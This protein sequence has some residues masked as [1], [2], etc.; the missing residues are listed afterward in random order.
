L[1]KLSPLPLAVLLIVA[2][3]GG[4]GIAARVGS[5]VITVEEV[6]ALRV[7]PEEGT[8]DKAIFAADLSEA[9]INR[10]LADGVR[11]EFGIEPTA[12]ELAAKV[13]EFRDLVNEQQGMELEEFLLSRE[14]TP[15]RFDIITYQAVVRDRMI[16][17]FRPRIVPA[18]AAEAQDLI[19]EQGLAVINACVSHILVATESE[20]QLA[21]ARIDGGEDFA[22]VARELGTDGTAPGG[23]SLGCAPL[24]NYVVEFAEAANEAPLNKVVGPVESDF[25]WHLIL[26]TERTD[27]DELR[28]NLDQEKINVLIAEW[29]E[30]EL[31]TAT[32]E[33]EGRYGTWATDP[34][35]QVV[36][37][38][39]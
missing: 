8:V 14:I 25:G 10:I 2:A 6:N 35:P 13:Q 16:D 36:P 3:C 34:N 37:P 18:T 38:S 27:I 39:G 30:Q 1:R 11:D 32:V 9:I 20:A 31:R 17:T 24:A 26:V 28:E 23:G 5:T 4:G 33:V 22:A 7:Q 15:A 12:E 29:V 21:K 19:D